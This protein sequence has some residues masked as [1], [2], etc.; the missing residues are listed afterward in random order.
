M[1]KKLIYESPKT[2]SIGAV[3]ALLS[4]K[5]R[6]SDPLPEFVEMGKEDSRLVLVLS[7]KRDAYYVVTSRSCSC[8]AANYHPGQ[9]CKHSQQF[10]PPT[11]KPE[12]EQGDIRATLPGWPGG[13]NGLVEAA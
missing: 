6:A 1:H 13:H 7:K 2:Q 11:A 8:P 5:G 10:F 9:K 3:K 12:T 4:W